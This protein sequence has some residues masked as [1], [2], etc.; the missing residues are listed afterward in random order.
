MS[1]EAK[2]GA[3][4]AY[5]LMTL[6]GM[7]RV[8]EIEMVL[9]GSASTS[10]VFDFFTHSEILFCSFEAGFPFRGSYLLPAGWGLTGYIHSTSGNSWYQG[11]SLGPRLAFVLQPEDF[12]DFMMSEDS[13]VSIMLVP[14]EK[15]HGKLAELEH[16]TGDLLPRLPHFFYLSEGDAADRLREHYER[17]YQSLIDD[18]RSSN[19]PSFVEKDADDLLEDHLVAA[20]SALP[21]DR[22]VSTRARHGHYLILR[23]AENFMRAHLHLDIYLNEICAA[24]GVSERALRYAFAD[25]M[26]MSPNRYLS[27]L[28][29]S[30]A[31]K[32][33]MRADASRRSVKSIALSCGLWDLSRFAENYRRLFGELPRDTLMRPSIVDPVSD[34]DF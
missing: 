10:P 3:L 15:L 22:P 19:A 6:S 12:N 24:A 14:L 7:L 26:D 31:R 9:L 34:I 8:C 16:H 11:I 4:R 13:K 30:A 23:R 21:G 5:D 17:I 32:S 2:G 33:L 18:R 27:M 20:L 25:L 28:R 29:L 1:A